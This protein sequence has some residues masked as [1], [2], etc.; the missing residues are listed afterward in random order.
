MLR[1]SALQQRFKMSDPQA[2]DSRHERAAMRHFAGIDIGN[3][4]AAD[5]TMICKLRHLLGHNGLN[6]SMLAAVND[7]RK[8]KGHFGAAC[9]SQMARR[10]SS[11]PH[12]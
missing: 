3:E 8:S 5:A 1:I 9:G 7:H 6:R 2:K 10:S 11:M 4:A 12:R